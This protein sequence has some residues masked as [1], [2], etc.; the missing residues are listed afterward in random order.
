MLDFTV[1]KPE[2]VFDAIISPLDGLCRRAQLR[3]DIIPSAGITMEN[4]L[5]SSEFVI[6]EQFQ[7]WLQ[8][9]CLRFQYL[10]PHIEISTEGNSVRLIG[11]GA[12][13]PGIKREFQFCLYRQKVFEQTLPLRKMLIEGVTGVARRTS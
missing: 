4:S 8:D 11:T 12:D 7:Q 9:A 6:E 10:H 2:I 1:A 3:R 13:D 5:P